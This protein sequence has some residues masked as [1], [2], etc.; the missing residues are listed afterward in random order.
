MP[1]TIERLRSG[2]LVLAGALVIGVLLFFSYARWQVRRIGRDL[3]GKLGIEIQQSSEGFTF[4]KSQAGRTLFTLHAAKT[5]QYKNG[6]HAILHDVSITLYGATGGLEDHIYGDT[7]DYDPVKGIVRAD[8]AVQIDLQI[9]AGS[10]P[11]PAGAAQN[12]S[13]TTVH[14]QTAGLIFN[15]KTSMAST[16][17]RFEFQ[18]PQAKGSAVGAS[19]DSAK[20]VLI[21]DSEVSLDASMDGGPIS[22]HAHHAQYDRQSRLLYLL[23]DETEYAQNRGT[24]DQATVHFRVD[25]SASEILAQG[26]VTIVGSEGQRITSPSAHVLLDP[27][28]QPQ[29]V[30]LAGGVLYISDDALRKVHG[31]AADGTLSF[32]PGGVLQ[33]ARLETTVS[34]VDEEKPQ[35]QTPKAG[36]PAGSPYLSLNREVTAGQIDIDFLTGADRHPVAQNVL[37]TGAASMHIRTLYPAAP[38]QET[39]IEADRLLAKLQGG[40]ALSSLQG[41]GH[42][43]LTMVGSG[44]T[45]QTSTG[46]TVLLTFAAPSAKTGKLAST[47]TAKTPPAK[48]PAGGQPGSAPFPS[49]QLQSD[50]LQYLEQTGHVTMIQTSSARPAGPPTTITATAERATYDS[51]TQ[52]VRLYGDAHE[53]DPRIREPGGEL[54]AGA[55]ELERVTGNVTA[56]GQVQATYHQSPAQPG[57]SLNG[58]GAEPIHVVAAR[59]HMDRATDLAI[60]YGE[61]AADAR[62][63]Q[64]ADSISAPVLELSR[65]RQTLDAH[66]LTTGAGANAKPAVTAVFTS[67]DFGSPPQ[68]GSPASGA[69]TRG[70]GPPVRVSSRKLFYS[71]V[72]SKAVF[73]GGVVARFP[74][75]TMSSSVMDV[76]LSNSAAPGSAMKAPEKQTQQVERIVARGAVQLEQPGR[77]GTGSQLI[78]TAADGRYVLTGSDSL[79]PRLFDRVRGTVTGTSLIFNDRDDSVIVSSGQSKAVTETHTAK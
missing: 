34:V 44:A 5:I 70:Q 20:G 63:W 54:S 55:I 1:V 17:Q 77:K 46:D 51:P 33:K 12:V 18:L 37:A 72:D 48:S 71:G 3:P 76:Y 28:S 75:G 21:L 31:S 32:G 66:G 10:N 58:N 8:G 45:N 64:A 9:S 52:V 50:Q 78:Y 40:T 35:P 49:D 15:E 24:S 56:E 69:V 62:L 43:K 26:H 68:P 27:K 25:G 73:D 39:S 7:F 19:F 23:S 61:P 60:F 38:P 42:T 65:S 30:A 11:P 22:V 67:A 6:G 59:A 13:K 74:S 2:I 47:K 36:P 41:A 53:G 79:P 14:I 57:I 29:Q 16:S 4:S